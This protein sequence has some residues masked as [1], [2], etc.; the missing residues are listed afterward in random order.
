MNTRARSGKAIW[1]HSIAAVEWGIWRRSSLGAWPHGVAHHLANAMRKKPGQVCGERPRLAAR[2]HAVGCEGL[3]PLMASWG[4]V[5]V[6]ETVQAR[7]M[8]WQSLAACRGEKSAA[9]S[10]APAGQECIA[11]Y[12]LASQIYWQGR[13]RPHLHAT[14]HTAPL[15]AVA[16][17][18]AGRVL[19][20]LAADGSVMVVLKLSAGVPEF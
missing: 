20:G 17:L 14:Q 3:R 9:G 2:L 13:A 11:G 18:P 1:C 10:S 19:L 12:L 6:A 4:G 8:G 5:S 7:C 16:T 15:R